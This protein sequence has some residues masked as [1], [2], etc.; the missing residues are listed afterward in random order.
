MHA[1]RLGE[2]A[3]VLGCPSVLSVQEVVHH[4]LNTPPQITELAVW[5]TNVQWTRVHHANLANKTIYRLMKPVVTHGGT[6][7]ITSV[8]RRTDTDENKEE[9]DQPKPLPSPTPHVEPDY[10]DQL[11]NDRR[12]LIDLHNNGC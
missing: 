11:T 3:E 4:L 6:N 1:T 8:E 7:T 5:Q 10:L 12:T 2:P 9:S